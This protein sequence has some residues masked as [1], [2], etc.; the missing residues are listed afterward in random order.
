MKTKPQ[1]YLQ[2][3]FIIKQI[4]VSESGVLSWRWQQLPVDWHNTLSDI[5]AGACDL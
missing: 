3:T 5:I 4:S 1:N 2:I